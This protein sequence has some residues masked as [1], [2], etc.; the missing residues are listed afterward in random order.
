[1]LVLATLESHRKECTIKKRPIPQI[2]DWIEYQFEI[3]DGTRVAVTDGNSVA[4]LDANTN[5]TRIV[6]FKEG[7]GIKCLAADSNRP[8]LYAAGSGQ[9]TEIDWEK[10]KE[11]EILSVNVWD[12]VYGQNYLAVVSEDELYIWDCQREVVQMRMKHGLLQPKQTQCRLTVSERFAVIVNDMQYKVFDIYSGKE[13][14][15]S[16]EKRRGKHTYVWKS[17]VSSPVGLTIL[18]EETEALY[19]YEKENYTCCGYSFPELDYSHVYAIC[20]DWAQNRLLVC[21]PKGIEGYDLDSGKNL[22]QDKTPLFPLP[23]GLKKGLDR[24]FSHYRKN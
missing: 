23:E 4:L 11:K 16:E 10:G 2:R 9:V 19:F 21:T 7:A 18:D 5:E 6:Y 24:R 15:V 3:I 14:F 1:M 17:P 8:V 12:M 13:I 20:A 22:R